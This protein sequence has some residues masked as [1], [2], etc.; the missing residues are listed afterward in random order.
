MEE[1]RRKT[2]QELDKNFTL[3]DFSFKE[4]TRIHNVLSQPFDICGVIPPQ[5]PGDWFRRMP[6][7]IAQSVSEAVGIMH[8]N[9]AGGRVRFRTDS[10]Y[11]GIYAKLGN[12]G[13]MPHITLTGSA[14]F[15]LYCGKQH[16]CS[17]HPR[18][19]ITDALFGA[20]ENC[21]PGMQDYT[22]NLSLYS[23]VQ[24]IYIALDENA[25]LE[26][27]A[28][29]AIQKPM[30]FYGSSITQGGCAS[31][32]G[33]CYSAV[34]SRRFDCDHIN[35]G[36][37]GNGLGEPEM[38]AY[39]ASLPMSAFV[40]DYDYNAPDAAHLE[41]THEPFF[42]TV[43]AAHPQIPIIC[44]NRPFF[45]AEPQRSAIIQSTVNRARAQGDRH[46]HYL[47][48]DKWI[49]DRGL[50]NEATVDRIHPNDLGFYCMAQAVEEILRKDPP[51]A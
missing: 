24:E 12:V 6:Q 49:R 16:I 40:L 18:F 48:M 38:A 47:D 13:K 21:L 28:P 26:P 22:L 15:D 34:L 30:V 37:S 7:N 36:F 3:S 43:R 2:I 35:L 25:A 5:Y 29:Y 44:L 9:C 11:I 42:Q 50:E 46:V 39:I 4:H 20:T 8:K 45:T 23:D 14:G 31:R 19:D 27:A 41:K 32:P 10:S 33:T 1:V 17:I 51:N